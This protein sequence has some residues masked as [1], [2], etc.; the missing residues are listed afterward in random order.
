MKMR[1]L[2]LAVALAA[3][4]NDASALG[5]ATGWSLPR[6]SGQ[7]VEVIM[8][9]ECLQALDVAVCLTFRGAGPERL[10]HRLPARSNRTFGFPDS[11]DRE[12][13]Y[14]I[15]TCPPGGAYSSATCPAE[16]PG[17]PREDAA[18]GRGPF[19]FPDG[20]HYDGDL[21]EGR[22][23]G[24]GVRTWPGGTRHE[25]EFRDGKRHGHGITTGRLYSPDTGEAYGHLR[26]EGEWRDRKL[27]GQMVLTFN[28]GKRHE[29]E[30]CEF[31]AGGAVR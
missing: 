11:D 17:W 28:D 23:H 30:V 19:T 6:S 26:V 25:G 18:A 10:M 27:C 15:R 9:N 13:R 12:F 16:C 7:G 2:A 5:C 1:K 22:P 31:E 4:A 29:A 14:S 24:H 20:S 3:V 21:R 8:Y